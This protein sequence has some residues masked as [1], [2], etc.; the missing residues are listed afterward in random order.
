MN[1]ELLQKLRQYIADELEQCELGVRYA[2]SRE[3]IEYI[4]GIR[5]ALLGVRVWIDE[6]EE[7][8]GRNL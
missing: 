1:K 6:Q 7:Q 8:N 4:N 5:S 2:E 3:V